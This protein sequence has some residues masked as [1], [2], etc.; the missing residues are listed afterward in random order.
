MTSS[1]SEE[2]SLN[3]SDDSETVLYR[4][5]CISL[6]IGII[7]KFLVVQGLR[8][9]GIDHKNTGIPTYDRRKRRR[10]KKKKKKKWGMQI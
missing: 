2:N 8:K 1:L 5:N 10:R 9:V 7:L 3:E 4:K 6:T